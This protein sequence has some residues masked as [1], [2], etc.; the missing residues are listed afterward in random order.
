MANTNRFIVTDTF[1][2]VSADGTSIG[3][4]APVSAVVWN[5]DANYTKSSP[6][7]TEDEQATIVHLF[8]AETFYVADDNAL[9]ACA[10]A[11]T[12]DSTGIEQVNFYYGG[13]SAQTVT[14]IT[15]RIM[16][17]GTKVQGYWVR[18]DNSNTVPHGLR[19]SYSVR[20]GYPTIPI[21]YSCS[22]CLTDDSSHGRCY[23]DS[24][25]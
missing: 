24:H 17:D 6:T 8:L 20:R 9:Y 25:G 22:C 15:Q 12:Y 21:G 13:S 1:W 10:S 2:Q 7:L 4:S 3:V 11:D 18:I 14:E 16:P 19:R 23:E 5:G